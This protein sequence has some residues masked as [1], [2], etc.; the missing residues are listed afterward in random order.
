MF[1]TNI[2]AN[3]AEYV[4]GRM[5]DVLSLLGVSIGF[6]TSLCFDDVNFSKGHDFAN[7]IDEK[8]L[9]LNPYGSQDNRC[10]SDYQIG[11]LLECLGNFNDYK[12]IVF[13]MGKDISCDS[14]KNIIMNPFSDPEN[15]FS[16]LSHAD[17]VIYGV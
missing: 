13:N 1:D 16:L 10:L 6:K 8:I 3:K 11:M 17:V 9:I 4:S 7:S 5:I 14:Y 15:S 12:V 2:I